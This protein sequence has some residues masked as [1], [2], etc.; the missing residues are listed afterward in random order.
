MFTCDRFDADLTAKKSKDWRAKLEELPKMSMLGDKDSEASTNEDLTTTSD[1]E[2]DD[3]HQ[4]SRKM[5]RVRHCKQPSK[6]KKDKHTS[7]KKVDS[8]KTSRKSPEPQDTEEVEELVD[9]LAKMRNRKGA[10]QGNAV[11]HV[12]FRLQ[13]RQSH[14]EAVPHHN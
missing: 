11:K 9:K 2:S 10:K 7:R 12:L 3:K 4:K 13:K 6:A 8:D 5:K 1:S 14:A